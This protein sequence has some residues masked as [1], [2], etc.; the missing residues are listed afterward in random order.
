MKRIRNV[1]LRIVTIAA[2]VSLC[3]G[4]ASYGGLAK[5]SSAVQVTDELPV[6]DVVSLKNDERA[7]RIGAYDFIGVEVFEVPNLNREGTVDAAGNFSLPLAGQ[8][9]AAGLTPSELENVIA[10][11][12]RGR[13]LKNPQVTVNV[14]EVRSQRVTI[15]GAVKQ[16]GIYP[17][18]G[19]MS[20]QQAIATARGT[21]DEA[22]LSEVVIFRTVKNQRMA[23]LFSLKDIREGRYSDPQVYGNDV[24]VVG[25]S[26][27]RRLFKDV[28]QT[29][30]ALGIFTTL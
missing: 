3:G 23:A 2:M 6:P 5:N 10:G 13:Y 21:S 4:C 15:D 26:A 11:K 18:M 14:K 20:L 22:K 16:P 8:V 30:P 27:V 12:L 29:L 9:Q 7:Y 17:V 28:V 25:E 24:I 19:H 1:A